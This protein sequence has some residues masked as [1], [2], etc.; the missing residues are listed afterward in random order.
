MG[1]F[2]NKRTFNVIAWATTAIMVVLTMWWL[3]G[4]LTGGAG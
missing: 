3:Y 1:E 4:Q 2:V